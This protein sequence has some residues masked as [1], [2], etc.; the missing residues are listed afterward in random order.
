MKEFGNKGTGGEEALKNRNCIAKAG[1]VLNSH[2][3]TYL[4]GVE[5]NLQTHQ[6]FLCF[7]NIKCYINKA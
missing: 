7:F 5:E 1:I 4:Q 6:D 2:W 3:F